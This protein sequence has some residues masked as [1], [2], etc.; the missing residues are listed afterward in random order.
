MD[1]RLAQNKH[2]NT[3]GTWYMKRSN[4]AKKIDNLGSSRKLTI[5]NFH[6]R[7][8]GSGATRYY[9]IFSFSFLFHSRP[10]SPPSPPPP[11]SCPS[12]KN[13]LNVAT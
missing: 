1:E 5:I 7:L 10:S 6:S 13:C 2:T 3:L 9:F 8:A 11:H 12:L 4:I